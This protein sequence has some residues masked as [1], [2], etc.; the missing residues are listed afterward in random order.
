MTDNWFAKSALWL[1]TKR[2][3]IA[4]HK[5][6]SNFA[7]LIHLAAAAHPDPRFMN[8]I[9]S[10]LPADEARD[11]ANRPGTFDEIPLTMAAC[12]HFF[13]V[14][15]VLL[16]YGADIN[17]EGNKP[18][19]GQGI[20]RSCLGVALNMNNHGIPKAVK[21]LL[22]HG[23]DFIVNKQHDVTA[24]DMAIRSGGAFEVSERSPL[25]P[26]RLY[27]E[28]TE[29]LELVLG[30][31]S[32]KKMINHRWTEEG[33]LYGM[34]ALHWAII[35][36]QPRAVAVL[37]EAGADPELEVRLS[38]G[39]GSVSARA[40][41]LGMDEDTIPEEVRAKG[42]GEVVRFLRRFEEMRRLFGST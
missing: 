21:W 8:A 32:D 40:L 16:K 15:E 1:F 7:N 3:N 18:L 14:A 29:V 10:A 13:A 27:R 11:L 36:M 35:R 39:S 9:L 5:V 31:F 19:N 23:A 42:E 37:L 20:A 17:A 2:A 12:R 34:T 6:S 33:G 38:D 28:N 41:A 4:S 24:L 22:D 26:V 25:L 30:K